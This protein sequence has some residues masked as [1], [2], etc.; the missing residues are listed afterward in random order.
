M[1]GCCY[2]SWDVSHSVL[3]F[4]PGVLCN[5]R[6]S[7][8]NI[9]VHIRVEDIC[10]AC[11]W[12]FGWPRLWTTELYA[13]KVSL[14]PRLESFAVYRPLTDPVHIYIHSRD[15]SLGKYMTKIGNFKNTHTVFRLKLIAL[16]MLSLSLHRF[17]CY[18]TTLSVWAYFNENVLNSR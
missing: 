10:R 17:N 9:A 12:V 18:Q 7:A 14:N 3:L 16:T 8:R 4:P 15:G 11:L 1:R 5:T 6:A 13:S 2:Y